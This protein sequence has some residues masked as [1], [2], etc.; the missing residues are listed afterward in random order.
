MKEN[1]E[2]SKWI[3]KDIPDSERPKNYSLVI[4]ELDAM[5]I[6]TIKLLL[7][8]TYP[9]QTQPKYDFITEEAVIVSKSDIPSEL[10]NIIEVVRDLDKSN[11]TECY[12]KDA[13]LLICTDS[14]TEVVL[15]FS[16]KSIEITKMYIREEA[17]INKSTSKY[18]ST[19]DFLDVFYKA[20]KDLAVVF[21]FSTIGFLGVTD[22]RIEN[23]CDANGLIR[24]DDVGLSYT[25]GEIL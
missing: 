13:M 22:D 24:K 1:S 6:K 17:Y 21:N 25:S 10:L 16:S 3:G 12:L 19:E 20:L 9:L 7:F 18:K 23:W 4:K 11:L 5:H 2:L 8:S 15:L 14:G